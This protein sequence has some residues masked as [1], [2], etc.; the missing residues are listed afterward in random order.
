MG[1]HK[2]EVDLQEH[3][4]AW[5]SS[6]RDALNRSR[7]EDWS[8]GSAYEMIC[9]FGKGGVLLDVGC[10]NAQLLAHL[11]PHFDEVV[12]IDYSPS[13][14]EAAAQ[15]LQ[16]FHVRNA[17]LEVGDACGFPRSVVHADV[18]LSNGVAQHLSPS[19]IGRHLRECRRVLRPGGCVGICSIPWATLRTPFSLGTLR[20]PAPE[21]SLRRTLQSLH[22]RLHLRLADFRN[23]FSGNAMG[24]WYGR[25]E[26]RSIADAEGFDCDIVSSWYYEYRFHARLRLRDG[27]R[28]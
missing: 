10:G 22:R 13:M 17:R 19:E 21:R 1:A 9:L 18:I 3:Y 7:A 5:W 24:R 14:L 25:D 28:Q 4:R 16:D 8:S 26:V 11:A 23:D 6:K 20:D 15:R 12:G 27:R 2:R